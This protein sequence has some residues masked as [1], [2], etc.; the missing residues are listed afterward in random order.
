MVRGEGSVASGAPR[1]AGLERQLLRARITRIDGDVPEVLRDPPERDGRR[2]SVV[3]LQEVAEKRRRH[4]QLEERPTEELDELAERREDEMPG[5]VDRQVDVV[6]ERPRL[7]MQ[8]NAE[9]VD[10]KEQREREASGTRGVHGMSW[11]PP[12]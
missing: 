12:G 4:D 7:R 2:M 5:L 11:T 9:A 1:V 6:H 8:Q 10:G 3:L